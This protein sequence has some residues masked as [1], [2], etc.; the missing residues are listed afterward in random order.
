MLERYDADV[1]FCQ[2]TRATAAYNAAG[3]WNVEKIRFL[4]EEHNADIHVGSRSYSNSLTPIFVAA[5]N[6][7]TEAIK[8][9]SELGGPVT[10]IDDRI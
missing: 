6:G 3:G 1:D 9:L 10:S 2:S 5:E 7:E 4:G 8:A